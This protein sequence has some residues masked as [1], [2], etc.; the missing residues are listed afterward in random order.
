MWAVST[1]DRTHWK[2]GGETER[3]ETERESSMSSHCF[4]IRILTALN[5][6]SDRRIS[7]DRQRERKANYSETKETEIEK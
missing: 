5:R 6:V 3:E 4:S 7:I 1:N 2:K